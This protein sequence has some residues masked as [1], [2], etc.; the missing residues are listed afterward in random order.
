MKTFKNGN[1]HI[2]REEL[3]AIINE[4]VTRALASAPVSEKAPRKGK[5]KPVSSVATKPTTRREAIKAWED[6]KGITPESKEKYKALVNSHSEFYK[7]LWDARVNDKTYIANVKKLGKSG[8]N[9]AYHKH[10]CELA[11]IESKK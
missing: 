8:A 11:S 3:D 1:M 9:K 10:I 7:K 2:T 6:A 5:S 4:A